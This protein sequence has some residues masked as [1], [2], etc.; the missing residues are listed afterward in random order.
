MTDRFPS[1]KSD[2][3]DSGQSLDQMY[4]SN[5]YLNSKSPNIQFTRS[6]SSNSTLD[7]EKIPKMSLARCSHGVIAYENALFIIG[8]YDRGECLD[9]CEIYDPTTN[10]MSKMKAMLNRRGRAAVSFSEKEKNLYILGGSDGHQELNSLE[11]YNM[12]EKKWICK[13]FEFEL[14]SIFS[15]LM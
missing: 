6:L 10:T 12:D 11:Y 13:T 15:S 5:N 14:G 1:N 7:S 9:M 2:L 4:G 3:S 8:G